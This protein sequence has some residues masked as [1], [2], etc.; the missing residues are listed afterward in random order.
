MANLQLVLLVGALLGWSV[1][2]FA[3]GASARTIIS[4]ILAGSIGSFA[5]AFLVKE[6]RLYAGLD[7]QSWGGAVAGALLLTGVAAFISQRRR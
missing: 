4:H 5:G 2:A 6:G 3:S 1:A 7:A